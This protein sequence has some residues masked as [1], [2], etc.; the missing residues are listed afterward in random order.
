[1]PHY[2]AHPQHACL[3]EIIGR[4]PAMLETVRLARRVAESE[5]SSV[6]LQGES[7]TGKDMVA[8]AIHYAS[9]HAEHPF[10]AIN[11]AALPA[12]LIE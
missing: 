10:V 4:S 6:L 12:N 3:D 1:M 7:G 5:V 2:G 11:C 8:K 9:R